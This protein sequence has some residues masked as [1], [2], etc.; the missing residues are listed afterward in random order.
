MARMVN[1]KKVQLGIF[2]DAQVTD[3]GNETSPTPP[4]GFVPQA[5]NTSLAGIKATELGGMSVFCTK[6]QWVGIYA[7]WRV[8]TLF[9]DG[10][11][12]VMHMCDDCKERYLV[13]FNPYSNTGTL[14]GVD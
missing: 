10:T 1:V 12:F 14:G 13:A 6:H 5:R 8:L 4:I 3:T 11:S 2:G 7:A 9:D